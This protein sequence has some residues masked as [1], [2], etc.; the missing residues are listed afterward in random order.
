M[1]LRYV[2]KTKALPILA[3]AD[4]AATATASQYFDLENAHWATIAVQFGAITNSTIAVTVECSTAA[5]SNATEQT[6][7]FNY[8]LS[9]AVATD[10]MGAITAATT[11]GAA[12]AATDDNKT[13]FIDL[14][15]SAVAALAADM[16]FARVV[17]TPATDN[18]AVLVGAIAYLEPRYPGN[19]IASAT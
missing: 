13:L 19:T 1:S 12:L 9:S 11:T 15:P 17:I 6:I 14:D 2:E 4:I 3:P 10:S 8:R 7:G 18:T 5:S 16:Q